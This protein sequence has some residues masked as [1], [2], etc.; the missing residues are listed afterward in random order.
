[1]MDEQNISV[2]NEETKEYRPRPR[3]QIW[4]ARIGLVIMIICIF[5]YYYHI[6]SGGMQ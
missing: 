2:P 6:A 5:L 4:A 1:M 3:Y